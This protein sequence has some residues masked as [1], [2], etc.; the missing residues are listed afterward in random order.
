MSVNLMKPSFRLSFSSFA[1]APTLDEKLNVVIAATV[2][3]VANRF[4]I[5]NFPGFFHDGFI[6]IQIF[7]AKKNVSKPSVTN[8]TT[9]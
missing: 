7:R 8:D 1:T 2:K 5:V 6:L 4:L 3:S 9:I